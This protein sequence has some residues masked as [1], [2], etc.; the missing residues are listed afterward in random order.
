MRLISPPLDRSDCSDIAGNF[1]R[2]H[3]SS[4]AK[5]SEGPLEDAAPLLHSFGPK[6]LARRDFLRKLRLRLLIALVEYFNYHSIDSQRRLGRL[7]AASSSREPIT[8]EK[9]T[10]RH[11]ASLV[12][13]SSYTAQVRVPTSGSLLFHCLS[14]DR[15]EGNGYVTPSLGL[16]PRYNNITTPSLGLRP[17]YMDRQL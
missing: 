10:Q 8:C 7:A 4:A 1:L 13:T 11:L 6:R 15:K 9:P 3:R 5:A 17:R 14:W 12:T 16:R 2:R